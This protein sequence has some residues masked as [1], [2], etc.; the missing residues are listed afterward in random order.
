MI[1]PSDSLE[2]LGN[3]L[4]LPESCQT[5]RATIPSLFSAR[6]T[7]YVGRGQTVHNPRLGFPPL[8]IGSRTLGSFGRARDARPNG[9]NRS[10]VR[11]S[12]RRRDR[13]LPVF[14]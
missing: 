13:S 3:L 4:A 7:T 8:F 6:Q 14:R 2:E 10:Q 12:R 5:G 11:Y 1:T 9:Q